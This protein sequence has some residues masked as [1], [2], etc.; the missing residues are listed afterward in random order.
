MPQLLRELT[1]INVQPGP[2]AARND[3][4]IN[5]HLIFGKEIIQ[6]SLTVSIKECIA[7]CLEEGFRR[8]QTIECD[9]D[10]VVIAGL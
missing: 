7:M 1:D 2:P 9:N 5:E 10:H 3:A 8:A 4:V 6:T